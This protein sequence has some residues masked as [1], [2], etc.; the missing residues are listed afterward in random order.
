[1]TRVSTELSSLGHDLWRCDPRQAACE[2]GQGSS[3]HGAQLSRAVK[4]VKG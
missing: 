3:T 2:C 4:G 1:M